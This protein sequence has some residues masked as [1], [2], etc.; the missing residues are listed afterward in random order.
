MALL[1]CS[2]AL[3]VQLDSTPGTAGP[4]ASAPGLL[5]DWYA[6]KFA[7]DKRQAVLF[8]S[9]RRFLSFIVLE[10][11]RLDAGAMAKC[12]WGGLGQV[13]NMEGYPA[14]VADRVVD[15][16]SELVLAKSASASVRAQMSHLACAKSTW[17]GTF[18]WP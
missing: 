13:L 4:P 3:L 6:T 8:V 7:L 9:Q 1:H 10:G 14:L 5:G 17:C 11:R 15:S 16:Y 18:T 2:A 12:F